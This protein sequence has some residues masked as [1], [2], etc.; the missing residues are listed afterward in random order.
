MLCPAVVHVFIIFRGLS[1]QAVVDQAQIVREVAWAHGFSTLIVRPA[2]VQQLQAAGC[3]VNLT[4]VPD[5]FHP[6]LQPALWA[7][8]FYVAKPCIGWTV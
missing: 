6:P 3:E 2:Q 5:T 1:S 7:A 8:A 4:Q